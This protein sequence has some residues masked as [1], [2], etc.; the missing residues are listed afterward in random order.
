VRTHNHEI[1]NVNCLGVLLLYQSPIDT[2]RTACGQRPAANVFAAAARTCNAMSSQRTLNVQ[3]SPRHVH[4]ATVKGRNEI[5]RV[6]GLGQQAQQ[7]RHARPI[8][9]AR[10]VS[11]SAFADVVSSMAN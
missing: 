10:S 8:I 9:V 4:D 6:T 1:A 7:L 11:I 5:G 2:N 3:H